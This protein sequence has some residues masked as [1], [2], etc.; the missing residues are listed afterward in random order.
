MGN[1]VVFRQVVRALEELE[2]DQEGDTDHLAAQLL[3]QTG[4]RPRGASSG[5]QVVDDDHGLPRLD[6]VLVDLEDRGA[7]LEGVSLRDLLAWKL[8]LLA[9]RDEAGVQEVGERAAKN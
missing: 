7:V 4:G 9:H 6:R 2:L 8:A 3:D 5:K 1:D